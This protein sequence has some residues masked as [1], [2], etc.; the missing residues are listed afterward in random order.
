VNQVQE[1]QLIIHGILAE[2]MMISE[3]FQ[4]A[5]II[6]K[7]PPTW[8]DFKNYLEHKRNEMSVENLIFRLW[9]E[10]DNR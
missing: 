5:T 10:E 7:L 1:L 8:N 6:E 4:V 9:I 3:S 2:G